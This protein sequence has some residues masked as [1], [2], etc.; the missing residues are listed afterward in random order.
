MPTLYLSKERIVY[1]KRN[2]ISITNQDKCVDEFMDE[3]SFMTTT[4]ELF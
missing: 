2:A 1:E 4:F 3:E